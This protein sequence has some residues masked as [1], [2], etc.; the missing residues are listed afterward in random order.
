MKKYSFRWTV[1][2]ILM[3]ASIQA[4]SQASFPEI[5]VNLS[6]PQYQRLKS[7]EGYAYIEGGLRGIILYRVSENSII[8]YDRACPH[9]PE[10]SCAEVQVDMSSLFLIDHC[11]K[12]T[13][14]FSNGS[15]TGGP[16]Q[17]P[18]IQYHTELNGMI[19]KISDE[20]IN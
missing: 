14:N 11:C 6:Y 16:A 4:N 1:G 5:T 12:S 17:R 10:A 19:L 9:H 7:D 8:A 3:M 2:I 13:F 15:P 20:I 18:L